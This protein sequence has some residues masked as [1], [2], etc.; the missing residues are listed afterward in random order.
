MLSTK[1]VWAY[2]FEYEAGE[3]YSPADYKLPYDRIS[4]NEFVSYDIS[5]NTIYWHKPTSLV[6]MSRDFAKE[7]YPEIYKRFKHFKYD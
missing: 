5:D 7:N 4:A 1:Q 2:E 6:T 3:S